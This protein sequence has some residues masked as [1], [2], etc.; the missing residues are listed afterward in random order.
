VQPMLA[1]SM[2]FAGALR[3]AGDT[4]W[5]MLITGACI[6]LVRLPLAY[7]FAIVMGWG[8]VGAWAGMSIDMILRGGFNFLRFRSGGW[9]SIQV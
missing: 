6:W 2:I 3:G 7:L 8:L 9:K 5:P 4:R 1:A